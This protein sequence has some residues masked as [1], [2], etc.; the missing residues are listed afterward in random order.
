[1][2]IVQDKG[3][4]VSFFVVGSHV[5]ASPA[6]S[7]M[8]DSLKMMQQVALCNHSY[9]HAHSRYESY[10]QQPDSVVSDFKRTHDSLRLNNTIARTP[11]RNIWRI[12]TLQLTDMK[13]STAAADSLQ[14]ARL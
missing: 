5:F 10:Y 7:R 9:L 2:H 12:D 3:V 8:W 1:M 14:N 6:Q 4:P 13:K 11:G